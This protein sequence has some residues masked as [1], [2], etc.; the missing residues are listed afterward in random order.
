MRLVYALGLVAGCSFPHGVATTSGDDMPIVDADV[1]AP[2]DPPPSAWWDE[3]WPLRMPLTIANTSTSTLPAGFQISFRIAIGNTMC[4]T[5]DDMRVVH[6]H[7]LEMNRV[8]DDVGSPAVV[9]F[10]LAEPIAAGATS[11]GDY[12]LYC[13]NANAGTPPNNQKMIFD[14]FDGFGAALDTNVWSIKSGAT[15]SNGRLILGNAMGTDHGIVTKTPSFTAGHAVDFVVATSSTMGN[16]FWGGFESTTNNVPP[17]LIWWTN[18]PT[19]IAPAF[20]ANAS[21]QDWR[22]TSK[23]LDTQGHYYSVEYFSSYSIFRYDDAFYEMHTFDAIPPSTFSIRLWNYNST[24]TAT[25]DLVRVRQVVDPA[26]TVTI[27]DVEMKP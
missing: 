2:P 17:W 4:A 3:A 8:F 19:I 24:P 1:D 21:S 26:P 22:G 5:R 9:W 20:Q 13:G 23:N 11:V 6:M 10:P 7:T 27:G 16:Y 25:F 14:F 12:Y 18:G 15:V